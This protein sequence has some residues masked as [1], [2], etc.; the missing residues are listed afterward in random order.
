MF[1]DAK[2]GTRVC[3]MLG[4]LFALPVATAAAQGA[5]PQFTSNPVIVPNPNSCAATNNADGCVFGYAEIACQTNVPTH[6]WLLVDDGNESWDVRASKVQSTDHVV[7]LLEIGPDRQ[8]SIQVVAVDAQGNTSISTNSPL[9]YQADPLPNIFFNYSADISQPALLARGLRKGGVIL[10]TMRTSRE[11]HTWIALFGGHQ[12]TEPIWGYK[13]GD[14]VVHAIPR[15]GKIIFDKGRHDLEEIDL[16]GNTLRLWHAS[17]VDAVVPPGAT[18]V[19]TDTIHHEIEALPPSAGSGQGGNLLLLS[20]EL[21]QYLNYPVNE[22][23]ASVTEPRGKSVGDTVVELNLDTGQVVNEWSMHDLVDP[24][25]IGHGHRSPF[26]TG[27]YK[28]LYPNPDTVKTYD[29]THANGVDFVECNG[30]GNIAV[31][32]RHQEAVVCFSRDSGNLKWILGD[33]AQWGPPY[34]QMILA[35]FGPGDEPPY[36]QHDVEFTR[37]E[38]GKLVMTMYDNGNQ[39]AVAPAPG[40]DLA[41]RYSRLVQ[42]EIDPVAMTYKTLF[43]HGPSDPNH[44]DHFYANFVSGGMEIQANDQRKRYL[45]VSGGEEDENGLGFARIRVVTNNQV[46]IREYTIVDSSPNPV[47]LNVFQGTWLP[48][49]YMHLVPHGQNN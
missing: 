32:L 21:R 28:V 29:W 4:A 1:N 35:P 30:D 42:Y 41:E 7:P 27:V 14:R 16:A 43:S 40:L 34:D 33:P 25:R 15:D 9:A 31:S 13:S 20:T 26:W 5:A 19:A 12:G 23:D 11:I 36:H 48:T 46:I 8:V 22:L 38:N 45:I 18:S 10:A 2:F 47:N 24:Y 39:R 6:I 3:L 37:C 49:A 44:P 17:D